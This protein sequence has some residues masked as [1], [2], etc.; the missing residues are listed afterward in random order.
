MVD[1]S[2]PE[3]ELESCPLESDAV[4]GEGTLW[5]SHDSHV[6]SE[7]YGLLYGAPRCACRSHDSHAMC[8]CVCVR[9]VCV[10]YTF[11]SVFLSPAVLD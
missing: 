7:L 2:V 5:G 8:V 4:V 6:M 1:Y 9:T 3:S 10:V 11:K